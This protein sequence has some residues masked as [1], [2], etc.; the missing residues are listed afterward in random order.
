MF[1][2]CGCFRGFFN[3]RCDDRCDDRRDRCDDRRECSRGSRE[4]CFCECGCVAF[5]DFV[6]PRRH[7]ER[8]E[9]ED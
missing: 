8:D 7:K 9:D 2:I 1:N 3:N 4:S 6:L 5:P